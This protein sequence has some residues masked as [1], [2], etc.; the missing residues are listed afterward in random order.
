MNPNACSKD[1][2]AKEV[3]QLAEEGG[4]LDPTK[5][6]IVVEG[7]ECGCNLKMIFLFLTCRN[8]WM[9]W[10]LPSFYLCC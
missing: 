1:R 2:I 10:N 9:H 3:I 4:I 6:G 5:G 7:F 8:F